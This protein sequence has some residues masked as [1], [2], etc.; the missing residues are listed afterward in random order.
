MDYSFIEKYENA[1]SVNQILHKSTT[2]IIFEVL[3]ATFKDCIIYAISLLVN[4]VQNQDRVEIGGRDKEDMSFLSKFSLKF[5]SREN[6]CNT[7]TC[8]ILFKN[9]ENNNFDHFTAK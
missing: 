1:A 9:L 4:S 3:S 8:D 2:S 5:L 7:K 6:P